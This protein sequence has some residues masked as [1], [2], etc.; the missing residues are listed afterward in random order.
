MLSLH[1]WSIPGVHTA[2]GD[3]P[4]DED[5]EGPEDA[6]DDA[7]LAHPSAERKSAPAKAAHVRLVVL[8]NE[9]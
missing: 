3:P 4:A 2:S 5:D 7:P 1:V 6:A 9:R 8:I